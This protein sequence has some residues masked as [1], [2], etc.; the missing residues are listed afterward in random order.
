MHLGLFKKEAQKEVNN[1]SNQSNSTLFYVFSTVWTKKIELCWI[2]G[3]AF[4]ILQLCVF[5]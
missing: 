2:V 3:L 4:C 5:L 1:Y